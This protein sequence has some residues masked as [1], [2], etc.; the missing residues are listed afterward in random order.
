[1]PDHSTLWRF[2]EELGKSGLAEKIFAAITGQIE[3]AGFVLKQGTLIDASIIPAAVNPPPRP[4]GV[5]S[6]DPDGRLA[7]KLVRSDRDP[8]AAWTKKA[9]T[10]FF[11]Y[12]AHLAMDEGSRIIRRIFLTPANVNDTVP[13]DQLI[14]G[15]ERAL[16]ADKA[17][18]NTARRLRLQELGIVDGIMR[19]VSRWHP[20]SPSVARRNADIRIKRSPIEPLFAQLKHVHGFARARYRGCRRNGVALVLAAIAMNLKRCLALSPAPA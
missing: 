12:K 17:Y 19:R 16:Y 15:D 2:R 18:D 9:G 1:M 10:H 11:G 13:A 20:M 8:D 6:F 5:P 4:T 7:S 14:C 3:E